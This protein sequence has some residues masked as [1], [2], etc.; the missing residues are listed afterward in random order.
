[1]SHINKCLLR[2]VSSPQGQPVTVPH[3][4]RLAVHSAQNNTVW[5]EWQA[6]SGHSATVPIP[7]PIPRTKRNGDGDS[8]S[9]GEEKKKKHLCMQAPSP[10]VYSNACQSEEVVGVKNKLLSLP[11]S[12]GMM[13]G[14]RNV[15]G[16]TQEEMEPLYG[17]IIAGSGSFHTQVAVYEGA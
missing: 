12:T 7:V 13:G 11:L 10:N 17:E 8:L 4:L 1:M 6:W 16:R 5:Q 14:E 15:T 2:K 3:S 9:S